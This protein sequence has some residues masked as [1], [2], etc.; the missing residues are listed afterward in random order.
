MSTYA[1]QSPYERRASDK[2]GTSVVTLS[3][4]PEEDKA[5]GTDCY[6]HSSWQGLKKHHP[7]K[8]LALNG[9]LQE[10][11]YLFAGCWRAEG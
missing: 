4:K 8:Q 11:Y 7:Y 2:D 1:Y 9:L 6:G 3:K 5:G 10:V